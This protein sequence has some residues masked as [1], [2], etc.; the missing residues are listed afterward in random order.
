MWSCCRALQ[1][2]CCE[3]HFC[4]NLTSESIV[5]GIGPSTMDAFN[6]ILA[7][8]V[9]GSELLVDVVPRRIRPGAHHIEP[10]IHAFFCHWSMPAHPSPYPIRWV[11]STHL[12]SQVQS[13]LCWCCLTLIV[14]VDQPPSTLV[15]PTTH[16]QLPTTDC[17]RVWF[18]QQSHL[19]S[20]HAAIHL[21]A[22][23]RRQS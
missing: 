20:S 14:V 19:C 7:V 3:C 4:I 13:I 18:L 8:A 10:L 2:L 16:C 11:E 12:P 5:Q 9:H 15:Q 23:F 6:S 21:S 1:M 17:L 22:N